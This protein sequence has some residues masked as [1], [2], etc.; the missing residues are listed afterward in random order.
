MPLD[1]TFLANLGFAEILLWLLSFA[2]VFGVLSQAGKEGMPKD[3]G[4]RAIIAIVVAFMVLFATPSSLIAT[5]STLSTNLL[6]VILAVLTFIVFIEAAGVKATPSKYV[7]HKG[8]VQKIE[9]PKTIFEQYSKH[10]AIAFIIIAVLLFVG[11]GGLGLLGIGAVLPQ[12]SLM[13]LLFFLV[14]I[15]AVVWLI[16]NP[17]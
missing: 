17:A 5:L 2:V 1:L 3:K 14:V 10:F 7:A 13:T 16:A 6:L 12:T 9:E 15:L 4:T 8:K 11:A